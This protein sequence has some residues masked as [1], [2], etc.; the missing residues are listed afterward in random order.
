VSFYSLYPNTLKKIKFRLIYFFL[1]TVPLT[2]QPTI[3]LGQNYH[4]IPED[5]IDQKFPNG[6]FDSNGVLHLVWVNDSN[7]HKDVYY[8]KSADEGFSFS[9]PVRI[10]SHANTVVAYTQSG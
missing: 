1:I 5:N 2:A 4:I 10:N 3:E 8:A 9:I 7:S 6:A